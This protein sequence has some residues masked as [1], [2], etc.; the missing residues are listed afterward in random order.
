MAGLVFFRLEES[1]VFSF[2]S[3]CCF[4]LIAAFLRA[5]SCSAS[6]SLLFSFSIKLISVAHRRLNSMAVRDLKNQ[7]KRKSGE[8]RISC[9]IRSYTSSSPYPS[10]SNIHTKKRSSSSV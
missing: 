8:V 7:S 5:S 10:F 4:F 6:T 2:C 1:G 3:F 9:L